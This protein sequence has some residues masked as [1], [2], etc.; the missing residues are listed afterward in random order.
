ML[1]GLFEI[2]YQ[3]GSVLGFWI[4]YGINQR[5]DTTSSASWRVPMAVQIIPAGIVFA[6]GFLLHESPLWLMRKNKEDRAVMGLHSL[7]GLPA[8]HECEYLLF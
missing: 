4:N 2:S 6:G 8:D 5:M 3:V 1:T 7:R